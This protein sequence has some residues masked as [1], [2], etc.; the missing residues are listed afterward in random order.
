MRW[1]DIE[2]LSEQRIGRVSKAA[3]RKSGVEFEAVLRIAGDETQTPAHTAFGVGQRSLA[4]VV[5]RQQRT[6]DY[7][8]FDTKALRACGQEFKAQR[9]AQDL[10]FAPVQAEEVVP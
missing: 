10:M 1:R 7:A 8:G 3:A 5:E 6:A 9:A 2:A 4:E